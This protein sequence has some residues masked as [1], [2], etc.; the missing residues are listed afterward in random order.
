MR[1]Y[2]PEP[3][4]D[5]MTVWAIPRGAMKRQITSRGRVTIPKA[6]REHLGLVPGNRVQFTILEAGALKIT[7]ATQ[8]GPGQRSAASF[9]AFRGRLKGCG[10]TDD[11]IRVLRDTGL[12][13]IDAGFN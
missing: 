12:D 3:L 7:V 8:C 9:A 5:N 4:G 13:A 1:P 10:G 6:M 11:L 2:P